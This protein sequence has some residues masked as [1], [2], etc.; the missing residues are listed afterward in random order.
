MRF[1]GATS[2]SRLAE[3]MGLHVLEGLGDSLVGAPE[4]DRLGPQRPD[5][6]G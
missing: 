4:V 5:L 6:Q 3:I 2:V 1:A